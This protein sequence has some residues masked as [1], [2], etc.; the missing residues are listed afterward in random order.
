MVVVLQLNAIV[1]TQQHKL[2]SKPLDQRSAAPVCVFCRVR[3]VDGS[4]AKHLTVES[5]M[6]IYA[7]NSYT[8]Y[9]QFFI[10]TLFHSRF[11]TFFFCKSFPL[12]PFFF[13]FRTDYMIPQT[14]TVTSS[15]GCFYF[16]V[17]VFYNFQ[18]SFPCGRL[19]RLMWAFARTLKQHLVSYRIVSFKFHYGMRRKT[20]ARVACCCHP[21]RVCTVSKCL[22]SSNFLSRVHTVLSVLSRQKSAQNFD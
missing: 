19:S 4:C 2:E 6:V 18:L 10:T 12:Q 9:Y 5:Y 15:I 14:F 22:N 21:S 20:H 13:F 3:G 17:F 16:L 7:A 8:C 1:I 11:K